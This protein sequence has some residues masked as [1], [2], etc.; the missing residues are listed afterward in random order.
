[1]LFTARRLNCARSDSVPALR[2]RPVEFDPFGGTLSG[3]PAFQQLLDEPAFINGRH[4]SPGDEWT[5]GILYATHLGISFTERIADL[6]EFVA[7]VESLAGVAIDWVTGTA[8]LALPGDPPLLGDWIRSGTFDTVRFGR[9]FDR[10]LGGSW[11][12]VVRLHSP[13]RPQNGYDV[14]IR[15]AR[16]AT[17]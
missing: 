13:G 10:V 14:D 16:G 8:S 7:G 15:R 12:V 17:P 9:A 5:G 4:L 2:L 3:D 6:P 11:Q 1:M